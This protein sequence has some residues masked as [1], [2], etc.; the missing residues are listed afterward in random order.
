M[1]ADD[2]TFD[3][4][5]R[6]RIGLAETV[7]CAGKST[8]QLERILAETAARLPSLLLTRLAPEVFVSMISAP[9]VGVA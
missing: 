9:A 8:D 7:L 4:E 2:L 6:Q 1:T 5:R 3:F